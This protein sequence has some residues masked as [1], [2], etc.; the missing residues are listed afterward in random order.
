V[1]NK[2]ISEV[3]EL[4]YDAFDAFRKVREVKTLEQNDEF[5]KTI[6]E[7]LKAHLTVI[8]KLAMGILESGGLMDAADLDQ[9]MNTIL[10]SVCLISCTLSS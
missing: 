7:N 4:Y 1:R 10:R 2:N 9:F 8:P 6:S 3:Y 5:C